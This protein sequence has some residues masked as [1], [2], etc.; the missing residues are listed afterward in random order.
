MA[1]NDGRIEP[2]QKLSSAIS[3]RAWNR[4]Q[5]A[6]DVVL[7]VR[8]G[9][10]AGPLITARLP[11]VRVTLADKGWFGQVRV[12]RT[13]EGYFSEGLTPTV[14]VTNSSIGSFSDAE[15]VILNFTAPATD[16]AASG[17]DA[18]S[19]IFVCVGNDSN[20]YTISGFAF[21]RVRVFNYLHR[22]ARIPVAFTG[23]TSQQ[24]SD[25]AGCLDSAFWGPAKVVGYCHTS[26]APNGHK[27][28]PGLTYPTYEFRWA[29]IQF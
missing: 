22:Y 20:D 15:K 10:E 9:A 17:G 14:P 11:G 12:A 27:A 19:G 5:D 28:T 24:A 23:Q 1:R 25:V 6:A 4:A 18:Q 3:A 26:G 29:L 2:G 7:G 21:T 8:P 16:I 13:Y